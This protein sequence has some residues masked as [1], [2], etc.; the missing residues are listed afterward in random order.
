MAGGIMMG[1][2]P[3]PFRLWWL[4]WFALIPLWIGTQQVQPLVAFGYGGLWGVAYHG[5]ALFWITGIHPMPWLG[6]EWWHSLAIA[7]VVWLIITL[8]GALLSGLWA[9]GMAKLTTN[10][11]PLSRITIACALY[12]ALETV[13]SWTPLYWTALGYTQS[14]DNLVILQVSKLSG[15]QT[16]TALLV[17]VNGLLAEALRLG[18][19]AGLRYFYLS[20]LVVGLAAAYGVVEMQSDRLWGT[21]QQPLTVGII[22]GNIPNSIKDKPEGVNRALRN[23]TEGYIQLAMAGVDMVLT[24]EVAL[25]LVLQDRGLRKVERLNLAINAYRVPIWLGGFGIKDHKYTN[26]LFLFDGTDNPPRQYDKVRLVPVGE[27]IPW[28]ELLGGLIRFLSPLRGEVAAGANDQLVDS[29][30]GRM[31]VGICYESAYPQ[32]FRYQ[33]RAGGRL[34][35]TASNNAHFAEAMPA[36]HHAQDVARAV[37]T[38]RWAVRA[39]NTGYS[40]IVDPKGRTIWRSG[41]NSYEVHQDRV[42]LRNTKTLYVLL[43][44]WLTPLLCFASAGIIG[45][46]LRNT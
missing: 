34:I 11:S 20:A 17:A 41:I 44:D 37:E 13:W 5:M 14:P 25:P 28:Q 6:V 38:D 33:A 30:W 46:Q 45:H 42:Y 10:L 35:L 9:V 32:H 24:P 40:G 2:T 7:G 15:Q 29:P 4:G 18:K 43:G 27:Y 23:Y 39:T 8:F 21:P 3:D 12:C 1:L 16:V 31:I 19:K 36:Q 26:S 22:Q